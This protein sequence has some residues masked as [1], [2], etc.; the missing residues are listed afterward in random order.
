MK[1]LNIALFG[2]F[3]S[4]CQAPFSENLAPESDHIEVTIITGNDINNKLGLE[5]DIVQ[6]YDKKLFEMLKSMDAP[7]F[8]TKKRQI[9]FENP[10]AFTIWSVDFVAQQAKTYKLPS[11]KNYW[12]VVIYLHFID[13]LQNKIVIPTNMKK[14][15]LHIEESNFVI[16]KDYNMHIT[17]NLNID[18]NDIGDQN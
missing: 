2:L 3:L 18:K 17:K 12:G 9:L 14:I 7:T 4:G 13:N 15:K 8:K 5:I 6:I 11:N 10:D 1:L 16:A